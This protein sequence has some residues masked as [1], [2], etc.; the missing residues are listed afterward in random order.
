MKRG[1]YQAILLH[2]NDNVVCLLQDM[3]AGERPTAAGVNPPA[4]LQDTL[5]GHK[6]ALTKIGRDATVV[7]YGAVIGLAIQDIEPGEH[8]HLHNLAGLHQ[9]EIEAT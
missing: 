5:L 9:S 7:K 8:V 3:S 2:A 1:Q 6:I 4:L